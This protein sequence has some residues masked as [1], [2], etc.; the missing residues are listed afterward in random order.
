ME[1]HGEIVMHPQ[2]YG[3]RF[4]MYAGTSSFVFLQNQQDEGQPITMFNS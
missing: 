3:I 2:A 1:V 4:G